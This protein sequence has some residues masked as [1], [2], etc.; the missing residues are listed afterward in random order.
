[1]KLS[2]AVL[3]AGILSSVSGSVALLASAFLAEASAG[4]IMVAAAVDVPRDPADVIVPPGR[5]AAAVDQALPV[6][7]A[8]TPQPG[9]AAKTAR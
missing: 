8:R 3:V 4:S 6:D 9:T 7:V 5:P 2:E 1:M